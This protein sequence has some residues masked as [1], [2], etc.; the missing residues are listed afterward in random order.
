MVNISSNVNLFISVDSHLRLLLRLF[1]RLLRLWRN[2]GTE[3][4]DSYI[5]GTFLRLARGSDLGCTLLLGGFV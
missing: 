2:S 3:Q 5:G 1:H 4:A